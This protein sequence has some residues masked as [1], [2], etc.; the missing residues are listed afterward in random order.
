MNNGMARTMA[1]AIRMPAM[2]NMI[3]V[4]KPSPDIM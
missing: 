4:L 2:M 1:S 3:S